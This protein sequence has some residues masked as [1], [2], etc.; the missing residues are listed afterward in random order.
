MRAYQQV[1]GGLILLLEWVLIAMVVVITLDVLWGVLSRALGSMASSMNAQADGRAWMLAASAWL[2]SGQAIYTDELARVL[3]VWISMLG[4]ALAFARKA[5][6]G[7][8][9][10]VGKM[11]PDARKL[12]AII[13]Q[14][15][16]VAFAVSVMIIG[17]AV[18]AQ[19]QWEQQLPTMPWLTKGI[20]YAVI[21]VAGFFIL[22]FSLENL[23]SVIRT[24]ADS[25]DA[26]QQSEAKS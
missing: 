19:G 7:V 2:P 21:P 22:M 8:D 24:P 25:V 13:V 26:Q 17:G 3:L 20:V 11:H 1:R 10:F 14:C 15:V 23:V 4:G 12:L 5:H 9:F 18:L 6:L 16:T